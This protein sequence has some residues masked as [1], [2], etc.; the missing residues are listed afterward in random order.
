M[1]PCPFVVCACILA[2]GSIPVHAEQ[3]KDRHDKVPAA[4]AAHSE[5]P[6]PIII[7]RPNGQISA[8]SEETDAVM[9]TIGRDPTPGASQAIHC[10]G[11]QTISEAEGDIRNATC[12]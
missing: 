6:A 1:K 12:K 7:T 10:H 3:N 4:N 11:G 9:D 8:D 5:P 2:L